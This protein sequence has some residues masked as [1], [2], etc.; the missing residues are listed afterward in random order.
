MIRRD[1][2]LGSSMRTGDRE[3]GL[4]YIQHNGGIKLLISEYVTVTVNSK[5]KKR[6][7]EL[8]YEFNRVGD[9]IDVYYMAI[10]ELDSGKHW[11]EID[12]DASTIKTSSKIMNIT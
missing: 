6:Y 2:M 7:Q 5:T 1:P 10:S 12:L 4:C 9:K 8:G 11:V 3:Q